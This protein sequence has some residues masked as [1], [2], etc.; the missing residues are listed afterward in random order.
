MKCEILTTDNNITRNLRG[1]M[2]TGRLDSARFFVS[3]VGLFFAETALAES[4]Q[5]GYVM[6]RAYTRDAGFEAVYIDN[7]DIG[8]LL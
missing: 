1:L 2:F 6:I 7:A 3:S 5:H 4:A 8:S